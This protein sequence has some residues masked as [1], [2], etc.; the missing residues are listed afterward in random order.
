MYH[1]RYMDQA[2]DDLL[3]I[4]RSLARES[5]SNEIALRFTTRLRQECQ[6]LAT[7]PG[8]IGRARPELAEGLRSIPHGNYIILLQLM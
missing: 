2:R 5:G 7:L 1:L 8:T 4:R 6:R 3:Q